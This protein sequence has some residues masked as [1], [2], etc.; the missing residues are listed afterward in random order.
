MQKKIQR[1][2]QAQIERWLFRGK[3]IILYGARQVGKTTLSKAILA[4]HG[5]DG[6]YFNCEVQ[7]VQASLAQ[8]EPLALKRFLGDKKL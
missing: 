6:G 7:S 3:I 2:L 4:S 5:S 1:Q 8:R